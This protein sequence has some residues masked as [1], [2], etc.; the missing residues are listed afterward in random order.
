VGKGVLA[1]VFRRH[2][3][4]GELTVGASLFLPFA[5]LRFMVALPPG[6]LMRSRNPCVLSLFLLLG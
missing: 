5:L 6:E 3:Y 4:L 1:V 2:F